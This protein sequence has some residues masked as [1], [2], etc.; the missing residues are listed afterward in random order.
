MGD[1]LSHFDSGKRNIILGCAAAMCWAIW[2][3]RNDI[4]FNN[5][6]YTS[7]LQALFRGAYWLR[8]WSLLQREE[9]RGCIRETSVALETTVLQIYA[10]HDWRFNNRLDPP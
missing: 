4:C 2:R 3:C 10:S 1:W 5:V 9:I 7:F 8:Y 6:K